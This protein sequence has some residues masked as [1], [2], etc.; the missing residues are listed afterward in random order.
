MGSIHCCK[1]WSAQLGTDLFTN[2]NKLCPNHDRV[3]KLGNC[4]EMYPCSQASA[5]VNV[6]CTSLGT[7]CT[8]EL[9]L[10]DSLYTALVLLGYFLCTCILYNKLGHSLYTRAT[11]WVYSLFTSDMYNKSGHSLCISCICITSM[12]TTCAHPVGTFCTL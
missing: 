12:D 2:V 3:H 11:A 1:S 10:G 9:L 6:L 4:M 7:P 8:L 5:Y